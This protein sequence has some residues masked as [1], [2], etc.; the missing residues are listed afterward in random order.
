MEHAGRIDA[1]DPGVERLEACDVSAIDKPA[2][3]GSAGN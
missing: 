2:I 3:C 1:N